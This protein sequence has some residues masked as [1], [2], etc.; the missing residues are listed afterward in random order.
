MTVL[1][2]TIEGTEYKV[3]LTAIGERKIVWVRQVRVLEDGSTVDA[4]MSARQYK[5]EAQVRGRFVK[6]IKEHLAAR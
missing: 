2:T 4:F 1:K 5:K 3:I 6:E